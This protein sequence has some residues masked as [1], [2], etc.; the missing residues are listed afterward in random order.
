MSTTIGE[1]ALALTVNTKGFKSQLF[2]IKK[3]ASGLAGTFGTLSKLAGAAFSIKAITSFSK[4]CLE[5][6]SDLA[7]VQNVVDV[8]FGH[9]SGAV[10]EWARN[11]MT[12][13]GM[14]EKVAKEYMGQFGAMS[15]A[16]GYTEEMAY[17]QAAALTGLA[18]DVA[19]FY[20][21]TTDEAFTK[22]K[23]VYTGETEALK[24]LG[25]VM[26]QNALDE[27]A[28]QQGLGK[29]TAKMSE[30]EKVALR[31]SFVQNRLAAASGDFER[32]SGGWANQVRVLSLRF[33]ALKASIGQGLINAL[34]PVVQ[35]LNTILAKIQVV[36]DAFANLTK[37][38]FGDAGSTSSGVAIANEA[39]GG[40]A[41]NMDS[42]VGSA[43][44]YKK[45]LAGFDKLN[46]LSSGDSGGSGGSSGGAG[47]AA[48][49]F[50]GSGAGNYSGY[51]TT[52]MEETLEE[53]ATIV[54]AASLALGAI[55]T[56]TGANIPLGIGLMAI[57]AASLAAAI[58]ID[59]NSAANDVASSLDVITTI[60]S[61]A[62]LALGAILAIS[63]ANLPLGI[64]LLAIG[65]LGIA[66]EAALN[67]DAAEN[68]CSTAIKIITG[69]VSGAFLCLGALLA[70]SGVNIP[71][72]I[73]LL[74][75]G[76]VS[77]ASSIAVNWN[78]TKDKVSS[79]VTSIGAV[80]GGASLCLGALLAF[81][82]VNIPLG[83]GLIAVGAVSLAA[84]IAPNWNS[85]SDQTKKTV[86]IISGI[87][88]AALLVVG[89]ILTFS[90]ANIPLGIGML[91]AGGVAVASAIAPNWDSITKPIKNIA[92]K[93][94]SVLSDLW[95]GIKNGF[96]NC[97]NGVIGFMEGMINK[98]IGGINFLVDQINKVAFDVPDWVPGIGGKKFGFNLR[99]V[100][101]VSLP[102]LATGGYVA[103]NT[104][105][106]A[107]IGDN[108]HEGEIVAPE[109]KIA[110]AVA[111]G[112]AMVM[113][114]IQGGTQKNERPMYLTLK[115]GEDT[116]WEGFVDYHNSVVKMTGE[117]PLLI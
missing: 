107:I 76:A 108:K 86:G 32:T 17:D 94:K 66:T 51:D 110:E 28:L 24:T 71:L 56:F 54:G 90:G 23:A 69:V 84:A 88:G 97:V 77:L 27:Y 102:R 93:I 75:V 82:G 48:G 101:T 41:E 45:I 114:K 53:V 116:F 79:T 80:V 29:T 104:P 9:M 34:L 74:A 15:K 1:I 40:I 64:A 37:K 2:G 26:T 112:F 39:V 55:L 13:F 109:S 115:L 95:T 25:V 99:R 117:S 50:S 52:Q 91:A 105:Q 19:S 46:I 60:V 30:Q 62:S 98:I 22:L 68:K 47:G 78:K 7:E 33:D 57:G 31:L 81:T 100:N 3:Q 106:L 11:A 85:M 35:V 111:R 14:S 20:N 113:S 63:G 89:A 49:M 67:W 44:A 70:F 18:G 42:A 58:A 8:T 5:L 10:N 16:F 38:I 6:G 103:A 65:S 96:K 43:K 73:G 87:V 36:A 59:W 83:I 21:M 92:S 4:E 61:A 72:G 12:S